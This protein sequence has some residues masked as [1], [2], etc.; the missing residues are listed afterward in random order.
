M[1]KLLLLAG[2]IVLVHAGSPAHTRHV[3]VSFGVF[4]SSLS[5]HGEWIAIGGDVHAWRPVRVP[6][7][8]RPYMYGRWVWT[9]YGWYWVSDE[10]WAWA[11][12]HYGRWYYDDYYGWIWIPGYDWAPAWVEWRYG[13]GYF[14]WAPLGPYAVFSIKIGIHYRYRWTTPHH[15]WTFVDCGYVSHPNLHRY[16][17]R[18]ED[19]TR[20][21]GRTRGAGNV[22]YRDGRVVTHG[23]ERDYVERAGKIRVARADV[24][25][26]DD[27][28]S[29]GV[30]RSGDREKIG[31]YRPRI[32]ERGADR[33]MERPGNVRQAERKINLDDRNL[34]VRLR[35]VQRDQGRDMK[36][37]EEVQRSRREDAQRDDAIR[38]REDDRRDGGVRQGRS[39]DRKEQPARTPERQT[40]G[41]EQ[42]RERNPEPRKDAVEQGRPQREQQPSRQS[43][44]VRESQRSQN[45]DRTVRRSEPQQDSR[46][47]GGEQRAKPAEQRPPRERNR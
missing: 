21:L 20:Y 30:T 13:G 11:V 27:L 41:R 32:E 5:P 25:D 15:W 18:T 33:S 35:E 36:R 22:R 43:G 7:G 14:G 2:L 40:Q 19:N 46:P 31:A 23:P 8:W 45:P 12:F 17:Y 44:S 1:K 37:A 28:R 42:T 6:V 24:V 4:Y 39:D 9:D 16:V 47:R 10:P 26:V 38:Q 29:V 34:D 3:S